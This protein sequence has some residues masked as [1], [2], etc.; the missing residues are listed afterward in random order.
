MATLPWTEYVTGQLLPL[1]LPPLSPPH[2]VDCRSS[3]VP[4]GSA[5]SLTLPLFLPHS[6]ALP[7]PPPLPP[8]PRLGTIDYLAPEILGC[9]VKSHLTALALLC[10]TPPPPRT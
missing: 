6:H 3:L 1:C 5:H 4:R 8:T 9:P 7:P 2:Q 10:V